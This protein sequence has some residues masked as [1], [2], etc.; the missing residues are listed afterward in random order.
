[1]LVLMISAALTPYLGTGPFYPKDGFELDRCRT[2]WWTNL[3]YIN[4]LIKCD[5]GT[6][7]NL[8]FNLI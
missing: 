7:V 4:N 2:T 3:L 5:S 6:S 1:M 8:Q